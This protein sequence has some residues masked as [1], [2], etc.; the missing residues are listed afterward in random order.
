MT[1]STQ[2]SE[3]HRVPATRRERIRFDRNEF[4]GAFGDMGTDVPLLIGMALAA[5][6]DGTSV[7]VMFGLMQI[8]T[9]LVYRLPM[10]VQP[11][12]AMATIVIAK[13]ASAEMLYGAG[14]AVGVVMFLLTISGLLD[15]LA[16]VV[17]KCVVRGVQ[18]GL[19]LTLA[20]VALRQCVV[21]EGLVG[22]A[23]AAGAFGITVLLLGNRRLPAALPVVLLGVVYAVTSGSGSAF[24]D[25]L[26]FRLPVVHVPRPS[27][28]VT[29]FLVLGLPQIPLSLGNSILA[30]RQLVADLFPGKRLPIRKI[31]FTYAAMNLVNPW[32]GGV[33]T[34]HGSGGIA[35]HFAFGGRTGGSVVIYGIL[36]VV[37]GL[38]F[39]G[40]FDQVVKV[41]PLPI[42][43]VVLLFEAIALI[44]VAREEAHSSTEFPITIVV[45]LLAAGLPYGFVIGM[46]VGTI[47]FYLRGHTRLVSYDG[48]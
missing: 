39:G 20:S 33:P 32:F 3:A 46:I 17:P 5:G 1:P 9:G 35:G 48:V 6:L 23:L 25:P 7:L 14:L 11:L 47:L 15:G 37:L 31:G 29:G 26:G 28:I 4:A 24:V 27:D 2:L 45:G 42:L 30:T 8:L 34:C 21:S 38:F 36:F 19:G 12:K 10:P 18:L 22:Y 16:R 40:G 43:G 41:F 44:W 13:Q